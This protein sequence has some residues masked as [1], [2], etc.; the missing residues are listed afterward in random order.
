M[1]LSNIFPYKAIHLLRS[2][3]SKYPSIKFLPQII[4]YFPIIQHWFLLLPL[5]PWI[6]W[7]SRRGMSWCLNHQQGEGAFQNPD[8]GRQ[9]NFLE[10]AG[11]VLF[12]PWPKWISIRR[13]TITVNLITIKD[14]FVQV[15]CHD[16]DECSY[17]SNS[18]QYCGS[19]NGGCI[20]IGNKKK[21]L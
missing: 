10:P 16:L 6:H 5:Q 11:K 9:K 15:G 19:N 21:F 12:W 18:A 14:I 4:S 7:L 20:N 2:N 1:I 17:Y 3:I 13:I 8:F